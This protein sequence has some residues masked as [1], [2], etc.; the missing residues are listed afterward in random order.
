MCGGIVLIEVPFN[1][2]KDKTRFP[3]AHDEV[4]RLP[5]RPFFDNEL[6]YGRTQRLRKSCGVSWYEPHRARLGT[7][8]DIVK[9]KN[10]E[11]RVGAHL[12]TQRIQFRIPSRGVD[13]IKS[14]QIEIH[15]DGSTR[16]DHLFES[17]GLSLGGF[18]WQLW[19]RI[20]EA[21]AQNENACRYENKDTPIPA[22]A[23]SRL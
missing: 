1:V 5:G 10:R 2:E 22:A 12:E 17:S 19:C 11:K 13:S 23:R 16:N 18:P 14:I 6:I 15:R 4:K 20:S 7:A 21:G 3:V 8:Q 9:N